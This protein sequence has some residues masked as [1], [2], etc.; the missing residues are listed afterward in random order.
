MDVQ[1]MVRPLSRGTG[2]SAR[3]QG[4]GTDTVINGAVIRIRQF[5]NG[6]NTARL[7][8]MLES[9]TSRQ[10]WKKTRRYPPKPSV[11]E[12]MK[13]YSAF[14]HTHTHTH[15]HVGYPSVEFMRNCPDE[16]PLSRRQFIHYHLL[17]LVV[18]GYRQMLLRFFEVTLTS[19]GR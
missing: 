6:A 2:K 15:K 16:Q 12:W 1:H 10:F 11:T 17:C 3:T 8:L 14:L 19:I 7:A 4:I 9:M 18:M 5:R 13:M